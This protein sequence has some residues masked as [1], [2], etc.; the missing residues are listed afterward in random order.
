MPNLTMSTTPLSGDLTTKD[1]DLL[2][3]TDTLTVSTLSL[4]PDPLDSAGIVVESK[5]EGTLAE[6]AAVATAFASEESTSDTIKILVGPLH[7]VFIIHR[8][9]ICAVSSY[10]ATIFAS[11]STLQ[12]V[13]P[14]I[15]PN[16]FQLAISWLHNGFFSWD[17]LEAIGLDRLIDVY[18]FGD[19]IGCHTLKNY[20]MYLIQDNMCSEV[21]RGRPGICLSLNQI[22]KIF[23]SAVN[24]EEAPIRTFVAALVSYRLIFGDK[25]ERLEPIFEVPGFLKDFAAFQ[26]PSL[27]E[28]DGGWYTP[29]S[30]REDPRVRGFYEVGVTR[31]GFHICSF[32]VHEERDECKSIVNHESTG[33]NTSELDLEE[34]LCH[35]HEQ[36]EDREEAICTNGEILR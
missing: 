4:E 31:K 16:I 8:V 9:R 30:L 23:A 18:L 28:Q 17:S 27:E 5:A 34:Q 26:K 33:R 11:S 24:A 10:F 14:D 32:H 20:T 13:L 22:R 19:L 2:Q 21:R 25:P 7:Q 1:G 35:E 3:F 36:M 29:I 15:E 6:D 12:V